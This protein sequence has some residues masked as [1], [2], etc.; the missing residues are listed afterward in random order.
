MSLR[1]KLK[2]NPDPENI[3][4]WGHEYIR[5]LSGE[6]VT[7]WNEDDEE[8]EEEEAKEEEKMETDEKK[9]KEGDK[10][11]EGEEAEKPKKKKKLEKVSKEALLQLVEAIVPSQMKHH[12]EA[13]ACDLLMEVERLD[14][15]DDHVD[16]SAFQRVCLYLTSCVPYVP[17]PENTRLLEAALRIFRRFDQFPQAMR[18]A[19]QLNREELIKVKHFELSL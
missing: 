1:Y 19:L 2:G 11:E 12:A 10:K 9:T 7:L 16:K 6:I 14:L 8:E 15:L 3:S 18:L 17:D 4:A 5:H 13:E